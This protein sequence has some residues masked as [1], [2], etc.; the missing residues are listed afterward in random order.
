M[1]AV[2]TALE[3]ATTGISYVTRDLTESGFE[4]RKDQYPG[5]RVTGGTENKTRFCFGTVN[6]WQSEF[7]FDVTGFVVDSDATATLENQRSTLIADIEQAVTGSTAPWIDCVPTEQ[8]TDAGESTGIGWVECTF[9][10][11]YLYSDGGP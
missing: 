6:N 10:A 3:S 1:T 11:T 4:W 5:V 9:R 2:T 7:Y 8:R